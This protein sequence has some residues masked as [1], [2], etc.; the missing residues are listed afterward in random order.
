MV[1]CI[2]NTILLRVF[3]LI[4]MI[5]F[6]RFNASNKP[7]YI[8]GDFNIDLLKSE[9]CNYAHNFLLSLQS[10]S[11]IPL[12]D[13]P[14]RV[15]GN[16]ATLIDNILVNNTTNLLSAGNIISDISDHFSQF[17]VMSNILVKRKVDG[18]KKVRDFS[19]FTEAKFLAELSDINWN[20][21]ISPPNINTDKSFSRFY[22]RFNKVINTHV[23]F[24]TVSKRRAKQ[25]SKPWITKGIRKSIKIKNSLYH[26]K[27]EHQYRLYRNKI[28]TLIRLSKKLYFHD[29]F[30]RNISSMK[31][32]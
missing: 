24:K 12:I 13:K 7:V 28:T 25:L 15:Y 9:S 2:D 10:Y 29:Y 18:L 1:Y 4:L 20:E 11:F 14:T 23:P 17:C 31:K 5:L 16:S 19:H 8:A 26:S 30:Q 32:T 22:N 21:I 3:S 6:E 27:F